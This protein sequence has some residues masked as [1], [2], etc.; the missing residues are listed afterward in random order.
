MPLGPEY[1][2]E[3]H[4]QTVSNRKKKHVQEIYTFLRGETVRNRTKSSLFIEVPES[5]QFS[6][7]PNEKLT[8]MPMGI[9][10]R[11]A[12]MIHFGGIV[13]LH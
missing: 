12:G 11:G 6:F 9:S 1:G 13:G 2:D 10:M 4:K 8:F 3:N 5:G 7:I